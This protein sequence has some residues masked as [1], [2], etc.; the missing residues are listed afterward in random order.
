MPPITQIV[1]SLFSAKPNLLKIC[2]GYLIAAVT[3]VFIDLDRCIVLVIAAVAI[4]ANSRNRTAVF[5]TG[6][7][8]IA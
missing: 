6:G 1:A 4:P 5:C 8:F 7:A 3:S 2:P